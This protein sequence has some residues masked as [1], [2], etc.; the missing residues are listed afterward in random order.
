MSGY[1][2]IALLQYELESLRSELAASHAE[3]ARLEWLMSSGRTVICDKEGCYTYTHTSGRYG[4]VAK[5]KR[6]AIDLAMGDE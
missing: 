5:T 6:E 3:V 4:P 1:T 2:E